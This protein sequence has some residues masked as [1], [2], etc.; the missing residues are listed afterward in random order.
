MDDIN[1]HARRSLDDP[2]YP[3]NFPAASSVA[4]GMPSLDQ[5]LASLNEERQRSRALPAT[6]SLSDR[7]LSIEQ[8]ISSYIEERQ[9]RSASSSAS[10]LPGRDQHQLAS[11]TE[12]QQRIYQPFQATNNA[13]DRMPTIEQLLASLNDRHGSLQATSSLQ[14]STSTLDEHLASLIETQ[15]GRSSDFPDR[16]MSTIEQQLATLI[17]QQQRRR[18][19]FQAA[20]SLQQTTS[21]IEEHLAS[22]IEEQQSRSGSFQD[23]RMPIMEQLLASLIG[24]TSANPASRFPSNHMVEQQTSQLLSVEDLQLLAQ[25]QRDAAPQAQPESQAR[26]YP[27][28]H[29]EQSPAEQAHADQAI[30]LPSAVPTED[31]ITVPPAYGRNGQIEAF[32]EKLYRLLAEAETDG[33]DQIISFT[34]DGR[35]FKIHN[36]QAFIEEVSPKYFRHAKITSFVRQLNF[37]GFQKLL[38]GPNRGGFTNPPFLRGHPELLVMIKRK[39]VAPRPKRSPGHRC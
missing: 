11:L 15:Q 32:P 23:M 20:S 27:H 2:T 22:L 6:S 37:Y 38:D 19:S 34:P 1:R 31:Q 17:E 13:P 26:S 4:N 24:A 36:R 3:S 39:E 21:T 14:N 35:A 33:N 28:G 25:L 16:R 9:R 29:A 30:P 8:Q 18:G 10:C 7:V 12:Q 5:R